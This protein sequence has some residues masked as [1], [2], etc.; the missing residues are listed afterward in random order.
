M[1]LVNRRVRN[2]VNLVTV[3]VSLVTGVNFV[4]A[5]QTIAAPAT[6]KNP[7]S[8]GGKPEVISSKP[9]QYNND[10]TILDHTLLKQKTKLGKYELYQEI[11]DLGGLVVV[12]LS[13]N[14]KVLLDKKL[15]QW[16]GLC[17]PHFG[18]AD[19]LG[20]DGTKKPVARDINN[21]GIPELIVY[22]LDES[23]H[24]PVKYTIYQLD[25]KPNLKVLFDGEFTSGDFKDVDNDGIFE[26]VERDNNFEGFYD[27]AS[28]ETL[29]PSVVL[30]WDGKTYK[31]SAKLMKKKAPSTAELQKMIDEAKA[32]IKESS[33]GVKAKPGASII[34]PDVWN[35]MI[36]L[37]YSGNTSSAK[38]FLAR[39][40][41][42]GNLMVVVIPERPVVVSRDNFWKAFVDHAKKSK[43]A[44]A[45]SLDAK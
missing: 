39:M 3:G 33:R 36:E 6:K 4:W 28:V 32:K 14:G 5:A 10:G 37:I 43:W 13:L 1:K 38:E 15:P 17:E 34:T 35:K 7:V 16:K 44:S 30:A 11:V 29:F 40:Y 26:V 42:S 23:A 12:K 24:G 19:P 20:D 9:Y 45:L 2:A 21:D 27:T 8:V 31:P 41:P 25:G 22:Y 18:I